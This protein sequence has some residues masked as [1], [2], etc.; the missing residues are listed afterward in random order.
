[1]EATRSYRHL[2][3]V[4]GICVATIG[5]NGC[6][7]ERNSIKL[8]SDAGDYIGR[9][10]TFSYSNSNAVISVNTDEG[11]LRVGVSGDQ[12]WHADFQLPQGFTQLEPGTYTQLSR[13]PFH[14]PATGGLDWS[15]DGRGCNTLTGEM[16]IKKA[17]YVSGALSAV[18]LSFEQHCEGANPALRGEIKWY[19]RDTSTPAG[20]VNPIPSNL[21]Q[22]DISNLPTEGNYFY[23]ESQPGDYIGGGSND[24]VSAPNDT[25]NVR[26]QNNLV[27][28]SG[29]GWTGDFKAMNSA[30]RLEEGYYSDLHRFPFNNPTKGGLSWSG[31][32]R[33][34]NQLDG[35]F[36]VDHV[37]YDAD[38]LA[39]I[40]IR[41]EQACEGFMPPLHG[42][43]HWHR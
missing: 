5:M 38:A 25:I 28:F 42:R 23:L 19:A 9:G 18:E 22:P 14:V 10:Q 2:L 16:T 39:S 41:F 24:L 40:D 34:C 35:W 8:V 17:T 31:N 20:P 1:M 26:L 37:E 7:L 29:G 4:I 32:G 15:G 21:W 12:W 13:Y 6:K 11:H 43:I 36:V 27:T 3:A 33:G 30:S